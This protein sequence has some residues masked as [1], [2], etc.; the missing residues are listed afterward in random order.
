MATAAVSSPIQAIGTVYSLPISDIE[1]GTRLRPIDPLFAAALGQIIKQEGQHTPIQVCRYK[2]KGDWA[3]SL[4]AGAHRL[5]GCRLE[6]LAYVKAIVLEDASAIERTMQEVSENLFRRSLDPLDRAA[7]VAELHQLLRARAG[8]VVDS[9]AQS[10]AANA[11]WQKVN[12]A[13]AADASDMMSLAYGFTEEIADQLGLVKRSIERD[14]MLHRRLP[15][16]ITDRLRRHRHPVLTNATQLRALAKLDTHEQLRVVQ[17]LCGTDINS[18]K[19]PPKSVAEALARVHSKA[20]PDPGAKR[21]SAF[22][23]NFQ[24]MSAAEKKGALAQLAGMLPAGFQ[25]VEGAPK[26]AAHPRAEQHREELAE[27]IAS[28]REIIGGIEED[29]LIGDGERADVLYRASSRLQLAAFPLYSDAV[30]LPGA[31]A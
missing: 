18:G 13:D 14:L 31:D 9:S 8:I 26:S 23:G 3:W 17:L 5:E 12:K 1:V 4:V 16:S 2:G 7:F 30:A 22:I 24:R 27:A 15:A 21:L 6:G 11:R 20:A 29:E 19:E 10:V 28:V 25:L